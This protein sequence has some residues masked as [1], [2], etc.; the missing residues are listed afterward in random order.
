[1]EEKGK[2]VP[3]ICSILHIKAETATAIGKKWAVKS[4]GFV[5]WLLPALPPQGNIDPDNPNE[6]DP[7]KDAIGAYGSY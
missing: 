7:T 4:R 3:V 5:G 2:L 6:Y 1:M